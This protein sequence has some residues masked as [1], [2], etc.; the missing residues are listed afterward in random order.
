MKFSRIEQTVSLHE[1]M[2]TVSSALC[3]E[4]FFSSLT[5][6]HLECS[7]CFGNS[8]DSSYSSLDICLQSPVAFSSVDNL[9]LQISEGSI[10]YDNVTTL[11]GHCSALLLRNQEVTAI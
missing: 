1:R 4:G 5:V 7:G 8:G 6:D 2:N 10:C 3:A 9:E 11:K